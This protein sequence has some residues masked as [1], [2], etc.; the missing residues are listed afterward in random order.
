MQ[1]GQRHMMLLGVYTIA[2]PDK[3]LFDNGGRQRQRHRRRG[4]CLFPERQLAKIGEGRFRS[5]QVYLGFECLILQCQHLHLSG[6][7]PDFGFQHCILFAG[8][9]LARRVSEK[10]R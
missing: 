2:G 5:V 9:F 10:S 3:V 8:C 6:Q 4:L 7:F 1:I